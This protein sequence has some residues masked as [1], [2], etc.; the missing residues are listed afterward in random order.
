VEERLKT[1]TG[2]NFV[3][4]LIAKAAENGVVLVLLSKSRRRYYHDHQQYAAWLLALLVS[5]VVGSQHL[6]SHLPLL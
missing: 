6:H 3:K 2:T 4:S 5:F 1:E